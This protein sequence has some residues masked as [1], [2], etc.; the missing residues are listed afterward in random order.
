MKLPK[1][2]ISAVIGHYS[3]AS[4]PILSP[5]NIA[6]FARKTDMFFAL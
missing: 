6:C 5:T 1:S 4:Y 2:I 3:Y